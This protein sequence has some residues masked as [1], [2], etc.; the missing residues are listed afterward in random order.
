MLNRWAFELGA[1]G[2]SIDGPSNSRYSTLGNRA[3]G[4]EVLRHSV[5]GHRTQGTKALA[6]EHSVFRLLGTRATQAWC[7]RCSGMQCKV[8]KELGLGRMMLS[9]L[10]TRES[11]LE[12]LLDA[13]DSALG[14]LFDAWD[15]RVSTQEPIRLRTQ[16]STLENLFGARDSGLHTQEPIRARDCWANRRLWIDSIAASVE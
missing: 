7:S 16:E 2:H 4:L 6:V 12:N 3:F 14:N 10:G 8:L 5:V 11:T 13:Q 15:S 1:F 9:M